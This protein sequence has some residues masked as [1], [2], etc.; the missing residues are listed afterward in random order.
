MKRSH[1]LLKSVLLV[2][3]AL[4]G[5]GCGGS[6][7]GI[8]D[9]GS[10]LTVRANPDSIAAD[11][12]SFSTITAVLM[13]GIGK[14][15]SQGTQVNF[16][17]TMGLFANGATS[18]YTLTDDLGTAIAVLYAGTVLGD[19]RVQCSAGGLIVN[20]MVKFTVGSPGPVAN[21]SLSVSATPIN[22]DGISSSVITAT[23]K[24]KNG[25]PVAIGT[26]VAFATNLAVFSNNKNKYDTTTVNESGTATATLIAGLTPGTASI[27]CSS[28]NISAVTKIEISS[29]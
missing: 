12:V 25:T 21:I 29:F 15:A 26:P 10:T 27:T 19:A 22:A 5:Y 9:A 13:G 17:T 28:N 16:V 24:D 7:T 23:L 18:F 14:P 20:T 6:E 2:L 3:I 11:G 4:G 8:N 1:V